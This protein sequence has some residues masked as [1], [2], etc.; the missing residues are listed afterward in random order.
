MRQVEAAVSMRVPSEA[1]YRIT[2]G[3][4]FSGPIE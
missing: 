2:N 1:A 3:A 4:V